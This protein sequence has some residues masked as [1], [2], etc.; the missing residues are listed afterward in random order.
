MQVSLHKEK[1]NAYSN[2]IE[3][4]SA[5][6][7]RTTYDAHLCRF[8]RNYNLSVEQFLDLTPQEKEQKIIDF[9]LLKRREGLS[10]Q[11]AYVSLIA[12]NHLCI[13]NDVTL[14]TKKLSRFVHH[15]KT[16]KY[17]DRA[18]THEEI[19]GLLNVCDPRMKVIVLLMASGG[20]RIGAI[21]PLKLRD[22]LDNPKNAIVVYADSKDKYITFITSECRQAID[23]YLEYRIQC[24][25]KLTPDSPLIRE[26]F[27]MSDLEQVRKKSRPI[28][29]CTI[30]GTLRLN[31]IKAGL[32]KVDRGKV[33]RH[34]VKANHG[35]RKFF[36][37]QLVEADLKTELRWLLEGHALK[38]NDASYVKVSLERLAE[39]YDKA[40]DLLTINPENRL[41]KKVQVLILEKSKIDEALAEIRAMKKRIGLD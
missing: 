34:E 41:K 37:T 3:S 4:L 35:F 7:T 15:N 29:E 23:R 9:L 12:V 1:S 25:E 32:R 16:R 40:I 19:F 30:A 18:Y 2:F 22:L 5:E 14:N 13:M 21:P 20:L 38:G 8:L 39:E 31:L 24:G 26:Q 33:I 27:D 28:A 11:Y 10:S 17:E 36:S 6:Q